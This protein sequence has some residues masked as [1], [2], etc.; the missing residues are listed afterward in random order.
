MIMTMHRRLFAG[1]LT[2]SLLIGCLAVGGL[3]PA[4]GAVVQGAS[5]VV[6]SAAPAEESLIH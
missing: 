6:L 2:L 4:S 1:L 5:A 3:L